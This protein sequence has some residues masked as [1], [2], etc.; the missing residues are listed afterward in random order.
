[1]RG[2]IALVHKDADS[3]WGVIFPDV[4]GCFS[5][6]DTEEDLLANAIE[7]LSLHLEGQ[8]TPPPARS[9]AEL[10]ADPGIAAEIAR[11]AFLMF[12]PLVTRAHTT[13]RAN[14]SL[15][16]GLLEA[17]DEAARQRGMTRSAFIA[18]A[19]MNEITGRR[20]VA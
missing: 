11:G 4:P 13:V 19:A 8:E 7:A 3:A 17:I 20:S 18:E 10:A 15:D 5:A 1:M 6:A 16:R 2:Y 9:A 14:I 12:V